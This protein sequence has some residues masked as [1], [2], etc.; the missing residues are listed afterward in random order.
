MRLLNHG[1]EAY[2]SGLFQTVSGFQLPTPDFNLLHLISQTWQVGKATALALKL[3]YNSW[4]LSID[5][6]AAQ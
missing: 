5:P 4:P 6:D 1:S 2:W 3:H